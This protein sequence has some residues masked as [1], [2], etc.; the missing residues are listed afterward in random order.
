MD[1]NQTSGN[2]RWRRRL[3][4]AGAGILVI[5]GTGL[6]VFTWKAFSPPS[7]ER[8]P[9]PKTLV[10]LESPEGQQL[11]NQSK[12]KQDFQPLSTHIET[13]KRPAYCGV[14]SS[15]MVLNALGSKKQ[16]Y[17]PLTQ[18]TFFDGRTQSIRSSYAVT[19][20]G[21]TLD[22]LAALLRSHNVKVEVY[23]ASET[24][25]N[26]F[27]TQAKANLARS[28]DYIIVN[29]QRSVL[30]QGK[31]GHI[32]PLAAYH[33]QSDRFLIEDVASY[34]YPPVWASTENLWKAMNTTDS[35]S[36]KTRGYLVVRQ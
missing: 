18:D 12:S 10:S 31:S 29:Y 19:F 33:E 24:T 20:S 28:G 6:S 16:G 17:R 9:L 21:M 22:E 32:S 2:H 14:A 36:K 3:I 26:Q 13:Q 34:K 35:I 4:K 7:V 15:V 8:L 5:F 27:R 25:L 11:L 1:L 30:G 23:Y